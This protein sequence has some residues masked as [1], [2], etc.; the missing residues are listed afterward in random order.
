MTRQGE[1]SKTI[2]NTGCV[3]H[4]SCLLPWTLL[5]VAAPVQQP[6]TPLETDP[7][8]ALERA[9]L[10]KSLPL[11]AGVLRFHADAEGVSCRIFLE[12]P[13]AGLEKRAREGEGTYTTECA[14][15][16]RVVDAEGRPVAQFDRRVPHKG[17]LKELEAAEPLGV[18]VSLDVRLPPGAFVLEAAA[19]DPVSRK[20][21]A[22]RVPFQV[23]PV[24]SGVAVS[25]LVL[26]KRTEPVEVGK[27]DP[28][29]PLQFH[30]KRIVPD[31]KG[32][33][34]NSSGKVLQ[35]YMVIY[36]HADL[37]YEPQLGIEFSRD[38]RI[39]GATQ[40]RLPDRNAQGNIAFIIEFSASLF[41]Q[42]DYVARAVVR[43]GNS[44][45]ESSARF[46]VAAQ[47]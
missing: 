32:L 22:K 44:E 40:P 11:E 8:A 28:A 3:L 37:P 5:A 15:F 19:E 12:V 14:F 42:G 41:R 6:A 13:L 36:P 25:S 2:R 7:A 38:G 9:P 1:R 16:A 26:L 45:A 33:V 29:D 4:L 35:F 18:S 39:A 20:Q 47:R 46:R 10:P 30:G 43:Q 31:L 34:A 17:P 21:A 23:P 24:E 27:L